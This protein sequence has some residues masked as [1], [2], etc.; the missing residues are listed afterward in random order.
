MVVCEFR[1]TFAHK[2]EILKA[3][4]IVNTTDFIKKAEM[5]ETHDGLKL[6]VVRNNASTDP[7]AVLII[8]HGLA[9]EHSLYDAFVQPF[10][11]QDIN[12][13]R[14]DARGHG[15]SEGKRGY[16]KS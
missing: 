6:Y 8:L 16:V 4:N 9:N 13:Y 12:V 11:Q 15:K 7:K 1:R 2:L 3:K 5:V 10:K 14:Y